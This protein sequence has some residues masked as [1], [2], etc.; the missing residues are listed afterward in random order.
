LKLFP[1]E[2]LKEY[3]N[4]LRNDLIDLS[5]INM[6]QLYLNRFIEFFETKNHFYII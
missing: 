2:D 1:S 6:D 4:N 3:K 5:M